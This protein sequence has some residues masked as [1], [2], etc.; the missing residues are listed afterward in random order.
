M[1]TPLTLE[2]CI[3]YQNG[4][5]W[6]RKERFKERTIYC[7]YEIS[8]SGTHSVRRGTF[9]LREGALARAIADC[10]KRAVTP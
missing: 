3:A 2:D 5:F 10:D 9:D 4:N 8:Q 6:V 1:A 7:V